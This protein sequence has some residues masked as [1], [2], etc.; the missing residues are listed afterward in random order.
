M[1]QQATILRVRSQ[2]RHLKRNKLFTFRFCR[3]PIKAKCRKQEV[4]C[5]LSRKTT[6]FP[7]KE[8]NKFH[9]K[10]NKLFSFRFEK[11]VSVCYVEKLIVSC[12]RLFHLLGIREYLKENNKFSFRLGGGFS[13]FH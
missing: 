7:S 3:K 12:F 8:N 4:S 1:R 6:S 11:C 2:K 9:L 13:A 10:R 5:F